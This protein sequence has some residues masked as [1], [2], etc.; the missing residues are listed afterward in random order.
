M[1]LVFGNEWRNVARV[2]SIPLNTGYTTS[3]P[4][5]NP[6]FQLGVKKFDI[7]NVEDGK[8]CR[9]R[10]K[11]EKFL[12]DSSLSVE[13]NTEFFAFCISPQEMDRLR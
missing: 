3:H 1:L 13:S 4:A 8:L 11:V 12:V 7:Y 10:E 5:F 9:N 6:A 2:Q